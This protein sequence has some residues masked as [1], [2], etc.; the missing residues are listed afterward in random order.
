MQWLAV[1]LYIVFC[2]VIEGQ[3]GTGVWGAICNGPVQRRVVIWIQSCGRRIEP[4]EA[5]PVSV[6]VK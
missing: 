3:G 2:V 5:L 6:S 1:S 4:S